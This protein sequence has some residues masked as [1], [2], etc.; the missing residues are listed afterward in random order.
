MAPASLVALEVYKGISVRVVCI[1][2]QELP[3]FLVSYRATVML[4][5]LPSH[6]RLITCLTI[7]FIITLLCMCVIMLAYLPVFRFTLEM[8]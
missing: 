6:T 4:H 7:Q 5:S 1:P 3:F 8:H 2:D